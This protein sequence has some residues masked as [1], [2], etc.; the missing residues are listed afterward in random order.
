MRTLDRCPATLKAGFNTY[1]PTALRK[2]FDGKKVSPI[3][4]F[5]SPQQDMDIQA[6]FLANRQRLS[7]SGYQKKVGLVLEKNQLRLSL[8]NEASRYILKPIPDDLLNAQ[9]V[10][11]NEHLT[12][13]IAEQ[14]FK[15]PTAANGLVFFPN[16]EPA[17]LTKRFDFKTDNLKYGV[18]DFATL[19][20]KTRQNAGADFKYQ[21]SVELLFQILQQYVGAYRVEALK[22]Y[23]LVLFNYVF[24]NGDAHLKNFSLIE[25]DNG[26]YILSPAYD[27]ICSRLH[28]PDSDI[29]LKDGLFMDDFETLSFR[30]NGYYAQADFRA[31]GQRVGLPDKLIEKE[32][33][34]F[35]NSAEKVK[36]LVQ[37]SF[38][39]EDLQVAYYQLFSDKLK[40]IDYLYV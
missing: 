20:Q 4:P 29:A 24:S 26:D 31:L 15:L 23:R 17:Y 16:D 30:A 3:L 27:L 19:A 25:T 5:A 35:L 7:I 14:V 8:P 36:A 34:L 40:R 11:A 2:L 6:Q 12:M 1:S 13:Q 39:R 33:Q 37:Q 32:I 38:L 28:V 9:E 10:P 18:E 22:L 21:G